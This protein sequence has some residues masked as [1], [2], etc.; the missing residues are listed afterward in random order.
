MFRL[1]G[2]LT[3]R[4]RFAMSEIIDKSAKRLLRYLIAG[5]FFMVV[6]AVIY[7]SQTETLDMCKAIYQAE[8]PSLQ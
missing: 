7:A 2:L 3:G 4:E 6:G 8:L 5:S 1:Y